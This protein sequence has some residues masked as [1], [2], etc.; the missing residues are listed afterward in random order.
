MCSALGSDCS[1]STAARMTFVT[2][3]TGIWSP[4]VSSFPCSSESWPM[5]DARNTVA[6]APTLSIQPGIGSRKLAPTQVGRTIASE[7]SP[8]CI[9]SRISASCLE[10]V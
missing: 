2:M 1:R 9:S 8:R 10:K 7:R 6:P 5:P 4:T 3:S